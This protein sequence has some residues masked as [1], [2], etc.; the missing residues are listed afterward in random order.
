MSIFYTYLCVAAALVAALIAD[1]QA[2][3]RKLAVD[4]TV[5]VD[6]AGS[7]G[8]N[9]VNRDLSLDGNGVERLE[10]FNGLE[11]AEQKEPVTDAV[12]MLSP[13][14]VFFYPQD[15]WLNFAGFMALWALGCC[16][17]YGL[18][19]LNLL[20][21]SLELQRLM[22]PGITLLVGIG[23]LIFLHEGPLASAVDDSV[24]ELSTA[25]APLVE[26]VL[27]S[28]PAW[29]W[30]AYG[31]LIPVSLLMARRKDGTM[32]AAVLLLLGLAILP[33]YSTHYWWSLAAGVIVFLLALKPLLYAMDETSKGGIGFVLVF[34]A[35]M[36]FVGSIVVY[37]IF[38]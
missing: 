19:R 5:D 34:L 31:L 13:F 32:L 35:Q 11:C 25:N 27:N 10:T 4:E 14:L 29:L 22:G 7:R 30:W 36:I 37:A 18:N 15:F 28:F 21:H 3:R 26:R 6:G 9:D 17:V 23:Y 38:F 16:A 1:S 20:N 2:Y 24:S 12:L 8:E 33:F